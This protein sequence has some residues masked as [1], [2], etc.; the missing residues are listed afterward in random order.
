HGDG[1]KIEVLLSNSTSEN[2][3]MWQKGVDKSPRRSSG[4]VHSALDDRAGF[5]IPGR[6]KHGAAV[7]EPDRFAR[8]G[9]GG[10]GRKRL[11]TTAPAAITFGAVRRHG[12]VPKLGVLAVHAAIN[13]SVHKHSTADASA[14]RDHHQRVR[15]SAG[16]EMKLTDSSGIRI[17]LQTD[18][19]A[20]Y[21]PQRRDDLC[22]VPTGERVGVVNRAALWIY[23]AGT[24]NANARQ[25]F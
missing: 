14:Q 17:V 12:N 1:E 6:G 4:R 16:A 20:K 19:D 15:R 22:T 25:R 3:P 5:R 10:A 24:A 18:G 9:D 8:R 11:P 13:L 2:D 21:F 7:L 23:R